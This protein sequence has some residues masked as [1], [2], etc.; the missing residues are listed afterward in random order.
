MLALAVACTKED[1]NKLKLKQMFK[2][3]TINTTSGQTQASIS[4]SSSLFTTPGNVGYVVQLSQDST[5]FSS[6]AV[7]DTTQETSVT[8][9]DQMIPIKQKFYARV[10]A[11]GANGANDSNWEV[12]SSFQVT[13]EQYFLPIASKNII[14]VSVIINWISSPD[15]V[16]FTPTSG[17]PITV[18]ISPSES[19][20][21]TKQIDGLTP[22]TTYTSEIF[23]AN[24]SKGL[25]TFT[26]LPAITGTLV[27]LE[28][29]PTASALATTLT[30]PTLAAGSVIILKRN[31]AYT[32]SAQTSLSKTVT[33]RSGYE[34]GV[35]GQARISLTSN[36]TIAAGSAID[37]IVFKDVL[38]KG[39]RLT[40]SPAS[41]YENDYVVNTASSVTPATTI[42][43]FKIEDCTVKILRGLVRLQAGTGGVTITNYLINNC[44]IDSIREYGM[45]T[46]SSLSSFTNIKITNSTVYKTRKF[47][48]HT[49]TISPCNSAII[50]NCTICESPSN[51]G[52]VTFLDFSTNNTSITLENCVFGKTWDELGVGTFT[53][54]K[55]G[56][57]PV[58]PNSFS[59]F[60]FNFATNVLS[61]NQYSGTAASVFTDLNGNFKIKDSSFPGKTF[62]D[63]RWK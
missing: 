38:L 3:V 27:H 2:P 44:V 5:G 48:T 16:V 14:D 13:G 11:M 60:D 54:Y 28:N 7:S 59:T 52:N 22:N 57:L 37:S 20:T 34:L 18:N 4:W 46:A 1:N 40:A 12:S 56:I 32:I 24:V 30:S 31:F 45:A 17:S 23:K 19:L 29:S 33:I 58:T 6:I 39:S 8:I 9:T 10:K 36:F 42:T 61:V 47:I 26:T 53:G 63:P 51:A 55:S 21:G 25:L 15:K 49:T 35:T 43:K 41:S 62:G 50:R